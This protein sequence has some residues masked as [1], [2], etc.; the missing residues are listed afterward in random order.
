LFLANIKIGTRLALAFALILTM[1][2]GIVAL[3][4]SRLS[5][6]D[7]LLSDFA[8]DDVPQVANSL[9]SAISLLESA[10]HT[11]NIFILSRDN[12][13]E[14]LRAVKDQRKSRLDGMIA[15]ERALDTEQGKAL[16]KTIVD[17]GSLYSPLEEEIIRLV[18]ADQIVEAKRLLIEKERPAQ[19]KYIAQIY[20][21]ID[22]QVAL[23]AAERGE[24]RA[25]YE[26]GRNAIVGIGSLVTLLSAV[27]AL[28][29]TRSIT[30]PLRHAVQ[31]AQ[32]VAAGDLSAHIE[33]GTQDETGQLLAALRNMM[34]SLAATDELRRRA[35]QIEARF[36]ELLESAPDAIVILD[37][38]GHIQIV[39][40][41]TEKL[42]GYSRAELL[43]QNI[44][45]LMPERFRKEHPDH[46]NDFLS[47][48]SIPP[49][50]IG[51]E[52]YGLRKDGSEF[53]AG[54]RLSLLQTDEGMLLS[55]AIRDITAIKRI[56]S[57]LKE[58]NLALE[59][60]NRAKDL[61]LA[62]MSHEI[63]TPMNGII[64]TLDVLQQSSLIGPQLE[65][66]DLIRESAD[67]L[68]VIID[69]ILDFSKI[70]AGHLA[71]EH[72]P[73]SVAEVVERS[74]NLV[75]R[76]AQRKEGVLTV[77]AD[78]A[79]P[80]LV[81][82]DAARLRQI[83]INLINNAIKFSS[84]RGL[85]G[86]VSV[87]AVLLEGHADRAEVEFAVTD[88]GIG[89]DEAT[90]ARI[91]TSF[92]QADVSTTRKYGGTGL[93]LA[94]CK[95]LV[96]LMD[97]Q[98]TVATKP[99]VGSTFTVRM[100]FDVTHEPADGKPSDSGIEGLACLV[101]GGHSGLADDLATYLAA[102]AASVVRVADLATAREWTQKFKPTPAVW[103]V[104]AGEDLSALGNLQPALRSRVDLDPGVVL[105]VIGRGARRNPK[106]EAKGVILIDGNSLNRRTLSNAVAVAAGRRSAEPEISLNDHGTSIARTPTRDEAIKQNRLILVAED[107]EINQKVISQQLNLL[108]Y[109]ADV[110]AT[111]REAFRCY[112]SG[113]YAVLLT[114][115]HMPEMDGYDLT[116]QIRVAEGGRTRLP[117]IAL[118]ANALKGEAERCRA[119]GMDD[120]LSK[121]APL[122]A[123]DAVLRKWL[124]ANIAVQD[125]S[126]AAVQVTT[127]EALVGNDAQL[128]QDLLQEF[129]V[130]ASNL[131]AELTAACL[132]GQPQVAAAIAHKLK[133]S[134]RS[135]GAFKLGEYCAAMEAS[136]TAQ[137][138]PSLTVLSAE[139]ALEMAEVQGYLR[140]LFASHVEHVKRTA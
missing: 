106:A 140:S 99:N 8:N 34:Q 36:R 23:V 96:N 17:T 45:L 26:S 114:D 48:Q 12:I 57:E 82:G 1:V 116:L 93:G 121:P 88:N 117:I 28:W 16:F 38:S 9:R 55:S 98:I 97:G 73:M 79:I 83:L 113:N 136:G 89:M 104:D 68:L 6:Q 118:T 33:V 7:K 132:N 130:S 128:I 109:A 92:T 71:I 62:S 22:Y 110:A 3:G 108:G 42:F 40:S 122:A 21:F 123:L 50:G 80:A 44:E 19:L 18:Q 41:Q 131:G 85:P 54:V 86:R 52:L 25:A 72:I 46:R 105:V 78:P 115:L 20:K 66:V 139:F 100:C 124:P 91:F 24:A 32:R 70:E 90:L 77:F 10:Q 65:L 129:A 47:H 126:L 94:I 58:K 14:E 135:V 127:L 61:F 4:V 119:V 67:S 111:G 31:T 87:R 74:C 137:N 30:L 11:R 112:Q 13:A 76:V 107:N 60:A 2:L 53:P 133:S 138:L 81:L 59:N 84:G 64:G 37:R 102:D 63:R 134:A 29:I 101:V 5:S 75:N 49:G 120:Y 51:V 125:S 69:D 15:V 103:I 39:N 43:N 27:F 56:E 35:S 95:Q